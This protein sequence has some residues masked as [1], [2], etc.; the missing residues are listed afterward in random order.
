MPD[1][2]PVM[3]A[4]RPVRS[5]PSMTSLAVEWKPKGVAINDI[6]EAEPAKTDIAFILGLLS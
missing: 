2:P 5:V 1:A 3:M 6:V 4:R